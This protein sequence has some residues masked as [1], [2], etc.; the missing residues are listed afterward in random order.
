M[1]RSSI[2]S[3]AAF[4]AFGSILFGAGSAMASPIDNPGLNCTFKFNVNGSMPFLAFSN[5]KTATNLASTNYFTADTDSAGNMSF[6]GSTM[7]VVPTNA[8]VS[9]HTLSVRLQFTDVSGTTDL[10]GALPNVTCPTSTG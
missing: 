6:D 7:S 2:C 1:I 4:A 5:G 8:S 9:G 3:I 10:S